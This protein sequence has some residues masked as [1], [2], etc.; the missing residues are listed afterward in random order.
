MTYLQDSLTTEQEGIYIYQNWNNAGQAHRMH[1][2]TSKHDTT[3]FKSELNL[4]K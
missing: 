2:G 4:Q 3:G 1:N